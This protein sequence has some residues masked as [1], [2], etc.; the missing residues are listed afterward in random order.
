MKSNIQTNSIHSEDIAGNESY[1]LDVSDGHLSQASH[2]SHG[3]L[4]E[5]D[6]P[7][8]KND[9]IYVHCRSGIRSSIAIGLLEH[10][11]YKD[12]QLS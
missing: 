10:E 1:V 3:K 11:S 6:L 5:T 2:V 9:V 4:L 8:N 7:F 12:I